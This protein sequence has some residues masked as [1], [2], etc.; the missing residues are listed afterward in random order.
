MSDPN[1]SKEPST[2]SM[3]LTSTPKRGSSSKDTLDSSTKRLRDMLNDP[4]TEEVNFNQRYSE[5]EEML[6]EKEQ[7]IL[8]EEGMIDV[9]KFTDTMMKAN[10]SMSKAFVR[11]GHTSSTNLNKLKEKR[12]T[13]NPP[14]LL[15][16]ATN[17]GYISWMDNILAHLK[18]HP[19]FKFQFLTT[20]THFP[21]DDSLRVRYDEI[22]EFI[23]DKLDYTIS[24]SPT[25]QHL[26][27]QYSSMYEI[28]LWWK[29]IREHFLPSSEYANQQRENNFMKLKQKPKETNESF[30]IR[31]QQEAA[32]LK[33][34]G[35]EISESRLRLRI[36]EG[37]ID[38][39]QKTMAQ[40]NKDHDLTRWIQYIVEMEAINQQREDS[41]NVKVPVPTV[42]AV[43]TTP[44]KD[45]EKIKAD[46]DAKWN[47]NYKQ[48]LRDK[49]H[50]AKEVQK[51]NYN[52]NKNITCFH[53]EGKGHMR[54]ACPDLHASAVRIEQIRHSNRR[55]M[56]VNVPSV[57]KHTK[58]LDSM[59]LETSRSS[60]RNKTSVNT[61][62]F[63]S[64]NDEADLQEQFQQFKDL[65][66]SNSSLSAQIDRNNEQIMEINSPDKDENKSPVEYL[67][68]IRVLTTS[69]IINARQP[70]KQMGTNDPLFDS[71]ASRHMFNN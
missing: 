19:D 1:L 20:A 37:L 27:S 12:L 24:Q 46:K 67:G 52:Y 25:L 8:N 21:D 16:T 60:P 66:L 3:D 68:A 42:S 69:N 41:T 17:M 61:V 33:F 49:A 50:H 23:K 6:P 10:L 53:C 57:Y 56:Y 64:N 47:R 22:Y 2:D 58:G 11:S 65:K 70:Y 62:Q 15:S 40:L 18:R 5:E 26:V 36:T 55:K 34:V 31:V 28:H 54:E 44:S 38:N 30:I 4:P 43:L 7:T 35:Q 14:L 9:N 63:Q 32:M 45:I 59:Q 39:F 51:P 48:L 29:T 71:G 13:E